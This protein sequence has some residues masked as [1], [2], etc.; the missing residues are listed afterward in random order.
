M[1]RIDA[2]ALGPRAGGGDGEALAARFVRF[3][4]TGEAEAGLFHP[5]VFCDFTLPRWRLQAHG[6]SACVA[7]R[8][9]GHPG[10]SR[11]ARSR[12]DATA[13]GFVLEVE[14]EWE[15]DGEAWYCREL[16]RAIIR[17]G[18]ILD[19]TVYCTG[20]WDRSRRA[21]HAREVRLLRP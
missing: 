12:Y 14:E 5:E 7:L 2:E 18:A 10:P 6:V 8:R 21:Q 15:Q 17:D 1:M 9:H 20:D 3:L 19:L 11:V 16:F 4:E 13:S